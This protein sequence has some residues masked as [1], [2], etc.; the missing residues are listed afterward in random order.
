MRDV[1]CPADSIYKYC[2]GDT[3]RVELSELSFG[4]LNGNANLFWEKGL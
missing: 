2:D 3:M 4:V 1:E